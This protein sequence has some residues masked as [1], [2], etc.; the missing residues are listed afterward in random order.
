M[1]GADDNDYIGVRFYSLP[2][3]LVRGR[4]RD[5]WRLHT[6][7]ICIF[8][9]ECMSRSD[10]QLRMSFSGPAYARSCDHDIICRVEYPEVHC[11][12]VL[13]RDG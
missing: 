6:N 9:E 1:G 5:R 13:P 2:R 10:R 12:N 8:R 3:F 11:Q 4:L 7:G